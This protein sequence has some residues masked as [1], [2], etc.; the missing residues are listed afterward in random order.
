MSSTAHPH[1]ADFCIDDVVDQNVCRTQSETN[2]WLSIQLPGESDSTDDPGTVRKEVGT[3]TPPGPG[4]SGGGVAEWDHDKDPSTPPVVLSGSTDSQYK[5]NA[6]G[7]QEYYGELVPDGSSVDPDTVTRTIVIQANPCAADPCTTEELAAGKDDFE[8]VVVLTNGEDGSVSTVMLN[9]PSAPGTFKQVKEIGS[10]HVDVRD[11]VMVDVN[12][13]GA[14]D[15][16]QATGRGSKNR[17]YYGDSERPGDFSS[18]QFV[19]FGT[20]DEA[21]AVAATDLDDDPTTPIDLV[22]THAD[23]FDSIYLSS[24]SASPQGDSFA[25]V[26]ATKID[27]AGSDTTQTNEAATHFDAASG[28]TVVAFAI[29]GAPDAIV[30]IDATKRQELING[31]SI[32]VSEV[33]ALDTSVAASTRTARFGDVYGNGN[34]QLVVVYNDASTVGVAGHI[35]DVPPSTTPSA[36]VYASGDKRSIGDGSIQN[37]VDAALIDETGDGVRETMAL[38]TERGGVVLLT[39]DTLDWGLVE[40]VDPNTPKGS[41][42]KATGMH[43]YQDASGVLEEADMDGDGYPDVVVGNQIYLSSSATIK[44]DFD[45]VAPIQ[46][47][48]GAAPLVLKALDADGDSDL[49]LFVLPGPRGSTGVQ[50]DRPPYVILNDGSGNLASSPRA[51]LVGLTPPAGTWN[52]VEQSTVETIRLPGSN[53]DAIVLGFGDGTEAMVIQP[54]ASPGSANAVAGSG[55]TGTAGKRTKK[56]IAEDLDQDG[57][58]E[59]VMLHDAG[60]DVLA[61]T[62]GATWTIAQS[63]AAAGFSA[64]TIEDVDGDRSKDIVIGSASEIRVLFG[65][66]PPLS[67]SHSAMQLSEWGAAA[68][69]F[70]LPAGAAIEE[71]VAADFDHNGYSDILYI[72]EGGS[73]D[74]ERRVAYIRRADAESRDFSEVMLTDLRLNDESGVIKSITNLDANLDGAS[75]LAFVYEDGRAKIILNELAARGSTISHVVVYN[76]PGEQWDGITIPFE[77]WV[78]QSIGDYNSSTSAACGCLGQAAPVEPGPFTCSC[79]GHVGTY[80]TVVLDGQPRIL[81]LAEVRIFSRFASPSPPPPSP[82]PPL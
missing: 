56:V 27:I 71:L 16:V 23:T 45:T 80:L 63:I 53:A 55:I 44:G 48:Q 2:A 51:K 72:R 60:V 25:D 10:D 34:A 14:L 4:P 37:V 74:S 17:V 47:A 64:A 46:F 42:T 38:Y 13:D 69:S 11:V 41:T 15:V 52:D 32:D 54:P 5:R 35:Y 30:H 26:Y 59:L 8:D 65:D 19:E 82:P 33:Y 76:R 39:Q 50:P 36:N 21:T 20:T 62:D 66:A 7:V 81:D 6:H 3:L 40:F 12:G 61:T 9:D 77:L 75:D 43:D 78:G 68:T 1:I 49:D 79:G 28:T 70:A 58:A 73:G 57:T 29:E 24:P 67:D 18:A 31:G 22:V